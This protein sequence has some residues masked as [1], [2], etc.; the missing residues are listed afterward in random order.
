MKALLDMS[1]PPEV[2][3]SLRRHGVDA[4]H[5]SDV[6]LGGATDKE[7]QV[8]AADHK[9]ALITTDAYIMGDFLERPPMG[10]ILVLPS[11]VTDVKSAV[12]QLEFLADETVWE[13]SVTFL[14]DGK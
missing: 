4:E 8:W 12:E 6:G 10:V 2:A 11:P 14:G 7:I 3:V 9:R 1:V 13:R 5:A